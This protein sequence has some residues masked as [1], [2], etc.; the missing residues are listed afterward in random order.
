MLAAPAGGPCFQEVGAVAYRCAT[1]NDAATQSVLTAANHMDLGE[2]A[3]PAL[4]ALTDF[5]EMLVSRAHPLLQVFT[6]F[7]SGEIAY[8]GAYC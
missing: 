4:G 1:C 8:V 3:P 2:P 7:P 5:E 6:L